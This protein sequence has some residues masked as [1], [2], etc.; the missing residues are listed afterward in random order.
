MSE[1][2]L[3][4]FEEAVAI[5]TKAGGVRVR[6]RQH[7]CCA[8]CICMQLRSW[9]GCTAC[10]SHL[11]SSHAVDCYYMASMQ[12]ADDPAPYLCSLQG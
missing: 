2:Q 6:N 3:A 1:E 9:L 4:Q 8:S 5:L 7:R 12:L 11:V 10:A